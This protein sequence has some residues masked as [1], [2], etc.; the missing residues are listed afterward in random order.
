[1]AADLQLRACVRLRGCAAAAGI[2]PLS[3]D[4][5]EGCPR[6]TTSKPSPYGFT[7]TTNLKGVGPAPPPMKQLAAHRRALAAPK[8]TRAPAAAGRAMAARAWSSQATV[9]V[10]FALLL[11][12]APRLSLAG[13]HA[14]GEGGAEAAAAGDVRLVRTEGGLVLGGINASL[15]LPERY[16]RGIPC[17]HPPAITLTL[18]LALAHPHPAVR[19]HCAGMPRPP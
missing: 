15:P 18:A 11:S 14:A 12:C 17:A 10:K 16:F 7:T 5:G 1:M 6:L 13:V 2:Q 4:D 9:V 3:H 19:R 8:R